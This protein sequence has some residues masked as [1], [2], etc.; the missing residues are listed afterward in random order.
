MV[1][2]KQDLSKEEPHSYP[3]PP[4]KLIVGCIVFAKDV[5]TKEMLINK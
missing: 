3:W 5:G 2:S 4:L 1:R